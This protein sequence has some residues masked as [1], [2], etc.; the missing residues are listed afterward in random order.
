MTSL[1]KKIKFF[2]MLYALLLIT[3]P[4]N[5]L[6]AWWPTANEEYAKQLESGQGDKLWP[7]QRASGKQYIKEKKEKSIKKPKNDKT[8]VYAAHIKALFL[9][10]E[11]GIKLLQKINEQLKSKH[12]IGILKTSDDT[13]K[14][15]ATCLANITTFIAALTQQ[16]N[17]QKKEIESK[18][19]KPLLTLSD[20]QNF[21]VPEL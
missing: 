16:V 15:H 11:K 19:N 3:L 20:D 21:D 8:N 12:I 10:H 6:N 13:G 4:Q 18:L 2:A 1:I 14:L 17:R 9:N 7:W 5:T